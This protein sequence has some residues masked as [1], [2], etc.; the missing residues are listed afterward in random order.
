[1]GIIFFLSSQPG[2][3]ID[4]PDIPDI[5]KILH[6][7]V[8]GVLALSAAYAVPKRYFHRHPYRTA[9]L[10]ILFTVAPMASAARSRIEGVRFGTKD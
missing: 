8:Y 9:G 3:T 6:A 2:D 4:L 5:D 10:V 7:L 1:M